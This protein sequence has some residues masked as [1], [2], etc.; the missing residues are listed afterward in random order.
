[1]LPTPNSQLLPGKGCRTFLPKSHPPRAQDSFQSSIPTGAVRAHIWEGERKG[2][3]LHQLKKTN[4]AGTEH[5]EG[6][7]ASQLK[8]II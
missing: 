5:P 8:E 4:T 2:V 1:M 7:Q 6:S 3:R